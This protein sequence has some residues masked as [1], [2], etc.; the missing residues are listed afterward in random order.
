MGAEIDGPAKARGVSLSEA[1]RPMG[2][3]RPLTRPSP[4]P[5]SCVLGAPSWPKSPERLLPVS[6]EESTQAAAVHWTVE[7]GLLGSK[8]A[9]AIALNGLEVENCEPL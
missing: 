4:S 8:R 2:P 1:R 3:S 9:T 6:A 5:T 7:F